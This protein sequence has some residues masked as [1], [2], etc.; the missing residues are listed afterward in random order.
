MSRS[1]VVGC[2][3][4]VLAGFVA[5]CGGKEAEANKIIKDQIALLDQTTAAF[6]KVT[7]KKSMLEADAEAKANGEKITKLSAQ[8]DALPKEVK[9]K[10][11]ATN[12]YE[13][14]QALER[15]MK[16]KEK[17]RKAAK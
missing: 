6:E 3:I 12:K 11:L 2:L 15:L 8:L 13:N 9:E 14:E 10:A 17:A 4:L 5:G 16:A 7:D 1:M